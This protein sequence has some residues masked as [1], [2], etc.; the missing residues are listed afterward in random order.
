MM[1]GSKDIYVNGVKQENGMDVAPV[2]KEGVVMVP[3]RFVAQSLGASVGWD[4]VN[5]RVI[6][7][8]PAK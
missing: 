4:G 3:V 7:T 6:L 1:I 8:Y 2:V 5:R